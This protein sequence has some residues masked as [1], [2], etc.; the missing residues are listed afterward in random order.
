MHAFHVLPSMN[1]QIILGLDFLTEQKATLD[2]ETNS[3]KIQDGFAEVSINTPRNRTQLV[4]NTDRVTLPPKSETI[5]P[6]HIKRFKNS[7][8]RTGIIEPVL[9]LNTQQLHGA[10]CL[11]ETSDGKANY[12]VMNPTDVEITLSKNKIVGRFS[13]IPSS[14]ILLNIDGDHI[15]E[16]ANINSI[17]TPEEP[18]QIYIQK[19]RDL[20]F[21]LSDSDLGDAQKSKLLAFLGK[22]SDIFA[23]NIF[24]LGKAN[25]TPHVIETGDAPPCKQRFY[26]TSPRIKKE[27]EKQTQEMLDGGIIEPSDTEWQAPCLLLKKKSNELRFTIDYR[28]LNKVT[29]PIT[30]P[31][32]R[33]ADIVD[34][35][36]EAQASIYSCVDL[37]N[38][39]WQIPLDPKTKHKT[40]FVTHQGVYVF[41]RV[42]FGMRN[43]SQVFNKAMFDVLRGLTWKNTLQYVDDLLIFSK[44]FD[45]HIDHLGQVFDRL[46]KAGLKLKPAKCHFAARKVKYL[47][48]IF[49]KHGVSVDESKTEIIRK[50]TIPR[51]QSDVRSFLGLAN[52]Y[53]RFVRGYSDITAP[54]NKLLKKDVVFKWS[55]E[56]QKAFDLL[57]EKLTSP[58]ILTYPS[59]DREFILYT[60]ASNFSI[61]YILGQKDD[62]NRECVIAYGGRS[63]SDVEKRWPITHLEGLA[64]VEGIKHYHVY[65]ANS[66][67][68][69]YTDHAALKW[70]RSNKNMSGRL[71]R[72][73]LLLQSYEFDVIHK[74]GKL[75]TNADSL[76]RIKYDNTSPPL[77]TQSSGIHDV[78]DEIYSFHTNTDK[79]HMHTVI[80]YQ[81][82]DVPSPH[83]PTVS[84]MNTH[85]SH[86]HNDTTLL[87]LQRAE[88][89]YASISALDHAYEITHKSAQELKTLQESDPHL[90]HIVDYLQSKTLPDNDKLARRVILESSDYILENDVLFH[91]YYPRGKGHKTDRLI[92]QLAVPDSLKHDI[93][94][95][96]HDAL[97]GGHQG[98]ERT[99]QSIRQKYFWFTMYKDI[100]YYVQSCLSCQKSKRPIHKSKPPLTPLEAEDVFVRV[101]MDFLGPFKKS[102]TVSNTYYWLLIHSQNGV[103]RFQ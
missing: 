81:L 38:S 2:F 99:Y 73:A 40:G 18:D 49:S 55:P 60:D 37:A 95:G 23:R 50:F 29:K 65:L 86:A 98:I 1:Y 33:L 25:V 3:L 68:T 94:L 72:W 57:K 75:H 87:A 74:P 28:L 48:H 97:A 64:L 12:K 10:R 34:A 101:H 71:A 47:G 61:S 52:Y 82:H 56:C 59:F 46:R 91:L 70:L 96:Y 15:N 27:I 102:P 16:N 4:I 78:Q 90:K 24:E 42:P 67:F 54:M 5:I 69:V 9:S 22:Y 19:A 32:P 8:K 103:K 30:F 88:D 84:A 63:L 62:Q 20:G 66:K 17:N 80:E 79:P 31:L 83:T 89:N 6:V 93:L 85:V 41:N 36:G 92:K 13:H 21:D 26:R 77:N 58:P 35:V 11:I 51:S 100:N 53:R 44:D 14:H 45:A 76:S 39:F 43:S 7:V